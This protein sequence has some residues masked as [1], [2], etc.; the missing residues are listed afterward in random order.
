VEK[1]LR[2]IDYGLFAEETFCGFGHKTQ[3]PQNFLPQT[4][5]SLNWKVFVQSLLIYF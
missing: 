3:K 4:L 2:L 1:L 5:F